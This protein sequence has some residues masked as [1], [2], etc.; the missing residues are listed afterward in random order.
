MLML[1]IILIVIIMFILI[2]P[3]T[4]VQVIKTRPSECLKCE[5]KFRMIGNTIKCPYCKTKY[6]KHADGTY[7]IKNQHS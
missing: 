7:R 5:R 2:L 3:I 4:F 6:F 1:I